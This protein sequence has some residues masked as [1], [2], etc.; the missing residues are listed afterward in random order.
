MP[1]RNVGA[2]ERRVS[3]VYPLNI[4]ILREDFELEFTAPVTF[5]VGENGSVRNVDYRNTERLI[6]LFMA[7]PGTSARAITERRRMEWP[8]MGWMCH[9]WSSVVLST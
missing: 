4:P 8:Q 2:K 3:G 6:D 5:L 7:K 1:R 9:N